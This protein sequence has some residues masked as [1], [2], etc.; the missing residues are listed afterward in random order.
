[1]ADHRVVVVGAGMAGLVSALQLA[2]QGL[3]VTVVEAGSSPGGKV[4]QVMV[5]GA[6]IDSGP[7]V[8]TMRWVFDQIFASVGT[9]LERELRIT[10]LPILA[11]HFWQDGSSLDLFADPTAS[12]EAVERFAGAAEA[13]RFQDFCRMARDAYAALEGPF[14][15]SPAPSMLQMGS[16]LGM[17][18]MGVLT[19]LGPMQSLWSS[20]GRYFKDPRMRQLFGRYATYCGSSP[21]QAPATLMLIAQVE[22]N[23]VW[24]VEGGM[25]ALAQ[26]LERLAVERGAVFRYNAPCEEIL[27]QGGRAVGVQLAGGEQLLADSVVF[28]GDASALRAGLL[29]QLSQ[30]AVPRRAPPRSLSAI[31]W[32]IH[33]STQFSKGLVLD[34]HNVF[35]NDDY[36]SEFSDIFE[37][38]RLPQEPTVYVCAQ[39]RGTTAQPAGAER[40]LC[41]VNAPAAGDGST[42]TPEAVDT[43]ETKS[44]SLMQRCGLQIQAAP[45]QIVRTLPQDF[46][47]LFPGTGGALYGQATHGWMSAFSRP[48]AQTPIPGLFLAGG[49][50]H[51]GPGVPMAAMSGQQAAAALMA[52]RASTRPLHPVA[53]SGGTS[54]R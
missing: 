2:Q 25:H 9:T 7:T 29:G 21:W 36:A 34:R 19:R 8:F 54:M 28:N 17:Q 42:I 50:V 51:P 43:C 4:R 49:S 14:I 41:L 3:Q 1:M 45:H 20:L 37:A 39:D 6:G 24:S 5:D 32:S 13:A 46:H 22:M 38:G 16:R 53:T 40:L 26:C 15:R 27:L 44:F 48:G 11:R 35:F 10:P 47:R 33:A 12:H 18:G 23:G 52:S 31:T 30:K